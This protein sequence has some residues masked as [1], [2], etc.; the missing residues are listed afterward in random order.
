MRTSNEPYRII[1]CVVM[2]CHAL[3]F[4]RSIY[5]KPQPIP[6]ITTRWVGDTMKYTLSHP[7]LEQSPLFEQYDPHYF[8]EHTLPDGRITYRNN[9]QQTVRGAE[10]KQLFEGVVKELQATDHKQESFT[11]FTVIKQR[12]YN[13]ET[14]AGLI[15]LK[16]K[17]YPFIIK[18]FME[19]PESFV[20]PFSKGIEPIWFFMM[21][22]GVNRY[23]A[24]FSRVK[25]RIT[26]QQHIDQDE[27]WKDIL[28]TPRKWFWAPRSVRDFEVAGEHIGN[29]AQTITLP[30]VYGIVC[31]A[32]EADHILSITSGENR[33]L[34]IQVSH[35]FGARVDPNIQNFMVEKGTN[36]LVLVDTEHFPTMVG[37]REP[38][39]YNTYADWYYQLIKKCLKDCLF[40]SKKERRAFQQATTKQ[41][42]TC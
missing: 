16:C 34:G 18:L 32:I 39:E 4:G 23:L 38:L 25:N 21:G 1:A 31:D 10:L 8:K 20:Q 24:G 27:E 35:F 19:T 41:P 40:R 28:S 37:L 6:T 15:I 14:H 22:G 30:S 2:L 7:Q 42:L 12:D 5:R 36:R 26:I 11:D 9:P 3:M 33:S 29:K 17:K 13:P